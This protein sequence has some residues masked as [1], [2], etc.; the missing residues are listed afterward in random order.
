MAILIKNYLEKLI[1]KQIDENGIV[2]WYDPEDYYKSMLSEIDW[3]T[4][5]II[6]YEDSYYDV[7]FKA[8]KYF[9]KIERCKVLIYSN[10]KRD[11]NLF[12][13][14]ELEKAGCVVE[15]HGP[16]ER[17]TNLTVV[18]KEVFSGKISEGFIRDICEKIENKTI[19]IDEIEKIVDSAKSLDTAALSII[20]NTNEPQSIMLEFLVNKSLDISIQERKLEKELLK[21]INVYL[22][23]EINEAFS[24]NQQRE[25]IIETMLMVDFTESL[26]VTSIKEKYKN[27]NL[28]KI[29]NQIS[30][31]KAILDLWRERS[32]IT[33]EYIKE[34]ERIQGIY[35]IASE[36][37]NPKNII[38]VQTFPVFDE[39][40]IK[41]CLNET[42]NINLTELQKIVSKRKNNFWANEKAEISLIWTIIEYCLKLRLS[43]QKAL[44]DIA[45]KE[46]DFSELINLYIEEGAHKGW[47]LIDRNYR[48]LES[49]YAEFDIGSNFDDMIEK[50][51][52][53]IRNEYSK[54]LNIQAEKT[55]SSLRIDQNIEI[56][57]VLR[58]K[59]ILRQKVLPILQDKKR[60]AYFLVDAFRYEMGE[61]LF[62]SIENYEQ[63]NILPALASIPTITPF[64]MLSLLLNFNEVIH[65]E[66]INKKI[67]LKVNDNKVNSRNERLKFI[68]DKISYSIKNFKLDEV[69]KP[70]KSVREEI[71]KADMVIVTSQ[72]IDSLCEGGE[73]LL[74]R[75]VMNQIILNLKRAI[76][77]LL[78]LGIE[79]FIISADHGYLLGN[80][81]GKELKV[82]CPNGETYSLH[83]RV[84]IGKGGNN[85][86]NTI[87][88]RA[89]DF[90]YKS[91]LDFVFP[92]EIAIFKT[93]GSENNYFHGGLSLQEMIIPTISLQMK[94]KLKQKKISK[95]EYFLN[96]AKESITNRIFTITIQYKAEELLFVEML[97]DKIKV[98]INVVQ[99][100]EVI[101]KAVASE[102]GFDE[103]TNEI[104]LDR[105]KK[106]VITIIL[107]EGLLEGNISIILIDSRTEM[108]LSKINDIP[109]SITI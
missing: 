75:Q 8:E 23:I 55:S 29:E 13:L 39:I 76:Y 94:P 26:G 42:D 28:P 53:K 84:W 6:K 19:S 72:E 16:V 1:K 66:P 20:F 83:K 104:V 36:I 24:L 92:K 2:V 27:L 43:I 52:I 109:L 3:G 99:D 89:S 87:R 11:T 48:L 4:V 103:A 33:E 41:F 77:H 81:M 93:T 12:P 9:E 18:I 17:N 95:E 80:E 57:K 85:P 101:G 37:F 88:F 90:G 71:K 74:A 68:E 51:I 79:E 56:K 98:R 107:N 60:C 82:N 21:L 108:E 25:K 47:Y 50:L 14:I 78:E 97:P 22:G 65:V 73:N 45:K 91:E 67:I 100:K 58:Q 63:K 106:N 34:S 62:E 31:I 59:D 30:A 64:G 61:E 69:I 105:N 46:L 70:K 7:R 15:P 54:L 32:D 10:I 35:G 38:D 102:Y 5:P 44:K 40:L 86:E 96:L 49:K